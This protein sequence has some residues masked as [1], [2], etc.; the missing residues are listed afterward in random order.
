M[1]RFDEITNLLK[2]AIAANQSSNQPFDE[3]YIYNV[4]E[5]Y[6]LTNSEIVNRNYDQTVFSKVYP[7]FAND[8]NLK[9]FQ[10]GR[11]FIYFNNNGTNVTRDTKYMKL[12]VSIK[13]DGLQVCSNEIFNYISNNKMET[14]SKI[15]ILDRSDDVVIRLRNP[16]DAMRVINFINSNQTIKNYS[17]TTNPFL[18][19]DGIVGMAFD[20]NLSYNSCVSHL[21]TAYLNELRNYNSLSIASAEGLLRFIDDYIKNNLREPIGVNKFMNTELFQRNLK[22]LSPYIQGDIRAKLLANFNETFSLIYENT[23]GIDNINSYIE[24]YNYSI[25][26]ERNKK[27][28]DYYTTQVNA[29]EELVDSYVKYALGKY[30]NINVVINCLEKYI[31]GDALGITR[32]QDFR[33]KFQQLIKPNDVANLINKYRKMDSYVFSMVPPDYDLYDMFINACTETKEKY[34]NAQLAAAINEG[35]MGNYSKF[36]NGTRGYRDFMKKNMSALDFNSCA[37]RLLGDNTLSLDMTL[38]EQCAALIGFQSASGDTG[39]AR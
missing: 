9:V 10:E 32:D 22:R 34:G 16:E 26:P 5:V 24:K 18:N 39:R 21:V 19:R 7:Q 14:N 3:K 23:K 11:C 13:H 35:I 2:Y 38:G 20:E 27:I 37:N 33:E 1:S 28:E 31:N 4:L 25:Q 15:S 6:G 29:K 30:K 36:T 8:P 12:Y 17:R